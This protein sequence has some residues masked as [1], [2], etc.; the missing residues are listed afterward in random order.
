MTKG[1]Y[2]ASVVKS[3]TAQSGKGDVLQ[4]WVS[5]AAWVI[6]KEFAVLVD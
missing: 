1:K 2:G 5:F 3:V 4:S 6:L